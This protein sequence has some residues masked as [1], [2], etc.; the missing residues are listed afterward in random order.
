MGTNNKEIENL[1][2]DIIR[3]GVKMDLEQYDDTP[4]LT[5]HEMPKQGYSLP[6]NEMYKKIISAGKKKG[7]KKV[8]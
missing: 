1:F 2:D 7:T 4:I 3:M 8:R 6:P 5:D